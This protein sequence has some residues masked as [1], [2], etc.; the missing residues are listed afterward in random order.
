MHGNSI[1]EIGGVPGRHT[2][3][4]GTRLKTNKALPLEVRLAD[5]VLGDKPG[6]LG[7]I[8]AGDVFRGPAMLGDQFAQARGISHVDRF[9]PWNVRS[10]QFSGSF[11]FATHTQVFFAHGNEFVA[12]L[13]IDHAEMT[14]AARD[15]VGDF[16]RS[17]PLAFC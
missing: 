14:F 17:G 12:E 2:A 9:H 8:L 15:S 13:L 11:Q 1:F 16:Q 3:L 4:R 6:G 10:A 7:A 5:G